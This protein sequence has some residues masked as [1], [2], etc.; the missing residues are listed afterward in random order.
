MAEANPNFKI[1][2]YVPETDLSPLSRMLTETEAFDRDGEDTSE[3]SLRAALEWPNFRPAQDVLVGESDGT[4]V[5]YGVALEQPSQR[6]TL[7]VVVHPAQRG[8][9]LGSQLLELTLSRAREVGSKTILIYANEHNQASNTFLKDQGFAAVGT[10]G[11]MIRLANLEIPAFEFPTGFAL[12]QFSEVND[13]Y[14]LAVALIDCYWGMWGHQHSERPFAE[15]PRVLRFLG[16]Y[17]ADNIFLL[18]DAENTVSG[19]CSLKPEGRTDENGNTLDSLDGPGVIQKYRDKG[20]QRQ[21]VLAGIR[22]LREHG[23]RAIKLEFFGDDEATLN[24][25][26]SL[27]FVMQQQYIAYYKEL[28]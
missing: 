25:Y 12:K 28:E 5:G 14:L 7:Y 10:S 3:E 24:I 23:N 6:C 8:K 18:F 15:N 26:R 21:L 2:H 22:Y 27:G 19:I 9:G 13:P 11:G 17:G 20:Y 4:L 16:H 1:R